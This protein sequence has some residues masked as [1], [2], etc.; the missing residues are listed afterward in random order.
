LANYLVRERGLPFRTCH[1]LV[2]SLVG[3]LVGEGRTLDDHHR[4]QEIL[5]DWGQELTLAEI[6]GVVDPQACLQQ[7]RSLGSTGPK[8]VRRMHRALTRATAKSREQTAQARAIVAAAREHTAQIV[9]HVLAG[10]A[11]PSGAR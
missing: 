9:K 1:E 5:A 3:T 11:L 7:Q 8:E 6:A 2:G 10:K 4:V